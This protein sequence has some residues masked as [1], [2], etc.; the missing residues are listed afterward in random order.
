MRFINMP[1]RNLARRPLRSA[2][3]ALG[4]GIAISSFIALVSLSRGV[5]NAW[6]RSLD[7]RGI[8]MLAVSRDAVEVLTA[9]IDENLGDAIRT[10]PAVADAAGELVNVVRLEDDVHVIMRGWAEG[11]FLWESLRMEEGRIPG[12]GDVTGV[13]VGSA[14][15]T[16]MGLRVGD[17]VEFAETTFKVVGIAASAGV[18]NDSALIMKLDTLQK[19]FDRGNRVTEF[20]LRLKG[21]QSAETVEAAKRRLQEAH[22]NL[23]FIVTRDIADNNDV[24][25]VFRATAWSISAVALVSAL[26][27]VLNT[28]LM[29]VTERTREIGVLTALGWRSER[30]LFMIVTEGLILSIVGGVVGAAVGTSGARWI[31]AFPKLR[32]LCEVVITWRNVAETGAALLLLGGIGSLYPALR[33]V[34]LKPT[35]ALKHE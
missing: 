19:V 25:R 10:D 8:H 1:A 20:A 34:S 31:A 26:V 28:L 2:L 9:T 32:G 18:M 30:V 23:S 14:L 13:V 11:S 29:S 24:L 3:T 4:I 17:P 33:A 35:D 27:V 7:E 5:E 6:V 12:E 15:S 21:T 16:V 22:P